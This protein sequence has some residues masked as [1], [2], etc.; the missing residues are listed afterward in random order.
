MTYRVGAKGQVVIPKPIRDRIGLLP[1]EEVDF[2]VQ[3]GRI[4]MEPRRRRPTL[5][6]RFQR[7]GMAARLL[8]D[9]AEE[10]E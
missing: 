4:V 1:G 8:A 6:G 7:T 10:P 2:S 5:G 9:R 3:A